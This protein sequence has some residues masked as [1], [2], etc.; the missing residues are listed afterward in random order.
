MRGNKLIVRPADLL[1]KFDVRSATQ[2][3]ALGV[4]M[5]NSAD[6]Q[7]VIANVRPKQKRL[8][9]SS[10]VQRDQNIGNVLFSQM[11]CL[12]GNLEPVRV[13]KC[14]QQGGNIIAKLSISDSALLQNV[15]SKHVKIKLRRNPKMPAIVQ[16]RVDQPRMIQDGIACLDV[17]Q[18]I[19]QRNL[20]RLRT[21]QSA[22]DEVEIGCGKPRPTIRSN[23][24]GFIMSKSRGDGKSKSSALQSQFDGMKKR[25]R[26]N[27]CKTNY[28]INR[29]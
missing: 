4:L 25:G 7:R 10:A 29:R 5:K 15:P 28:V 22:H 13:R 24:R 27:D 1:V 18:Q 19:D 8:F 20:V 3:A 14:F 9:R 2:T 26:I 17:A 16:N 6:E 11:M 12:V 23:H 21:R